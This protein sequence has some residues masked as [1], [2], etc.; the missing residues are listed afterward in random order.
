MNQ[1]C[2]HKAAYEVLMLKQPLQKCQAM[3]ELFQSWKDHPE[4][5][6]FTDS[7]TSIET[8]ENP[9]RPDKPE[10]V[11]PKVLAK[12]AL[13]THEGRCVL[14]HAIA[15]IEFNAINLA[16]DAVYRFRDQ[17]Q[18]FYGDWLQ[19]ADD[20]ARHFAM[21]LGYLHKHDINYGDYPAHNGLWE[22]VL[23]T[24]HDIV[25]RMALVPRVLEA[26]GLDV[27]PAMIAKLKQ[28]GDESAA[29]I[30]KVIYHDEIG[31]VEVGSRWFYF[32]CEQ[33]SLAPQE[34]FLKLIDRYMQGNLRGPFNEAAR[35][36]AGFLQEEIASL[37][38]LR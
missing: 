1:S 25:D 18:A 6:T 2:L 35:L 27:S 9:G 32:H 29:D 19:V 12:R 23:K 13:H 34:T 33:R 24:G 15:H 26:R 28:A 16:L 30:L 10:L 3:H 8:I 11:S 7:N 22:M 36:K 5:F 38:K 21:V 4:Q 37:N 20:E 17:P 31:H 14:M